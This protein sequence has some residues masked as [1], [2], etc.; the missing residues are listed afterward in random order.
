MNK[1]HLVL[2]DDADSLRE[3]V[4]QLAAEHSQKEQAFL[5]KQQDLES[6]IRF[7]EEQVRFFKERLYGRKSE[8]LTPEESK[9]LMLF[10]EAEQVADELSDK[11]EEITVPS[12]MLWGEKTGSFPAPPVGPMPA[13]LSIA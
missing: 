7:L 2:P 5:E 3:T 1:A 9:Q 8:K 11:A 10:N 13:Q 12:H 4:L 6:K